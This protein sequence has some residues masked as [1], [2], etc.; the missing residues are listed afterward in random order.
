MP[1]SSKI[2]L[3]GGLVANLAIAA[4]KFVVG[5]L[6][7]SSV[8]IAEGIHSLVDTGNSGLMMFGRR[9]SRRGP[10]AEHP[11]GYGMELYFWS[12]VVAIIVFGGGGGLSIYEG[13][14]AL[15]EPQA[16]SAVWSNYL[17]IAIAAVFEGA[18]LVIGMREFT[19]YRRER[20]YP[21]SILAAIR[22]SKNPAMFLTVLEDTAALVGLAIAAAGIALRVWTGWMP[23]DG[24]ASILIG[25]VQ[26]VEALVLAIECRGLIIG[27]PARPVVI[28][29][30]E[31]A[32][33]HYIPA[34]RSGRGQAGT[35]AAATDV[36]V[37]EIRTLQ[38]GPE[39]I[40]VFL[41]VRIHSVREAAQLPALIA[42]LIAEL[43]A[44]VPA[45]QD[46]FVTLPRDERE[47]LV[48]D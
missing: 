28:E 40:L 19:K 1:A 42:H 45:I 31:R 27:E 33:A 3:T 22:A 23:L 16:I 6:T 20:R 46:V 17:T 18:S 41:D 47:Q 48:Q 5:G 32:L 11:F 9:R 26:M 7:H 21:G 8:M 34:S 39:S 4:T 25:L 13:L 2:A 12:F 37:D 10:D 14:H 38:F 44:A 35:G 36:D 29:Q 43:R 24:I 30:I 15:A